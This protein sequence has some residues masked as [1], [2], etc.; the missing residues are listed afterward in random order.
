MSQ[1]ASE[2]PDWSTFQNEYFLSS[3]IPPGT[4]AALEYVGDP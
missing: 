4:P 2:D 3:L 1:L